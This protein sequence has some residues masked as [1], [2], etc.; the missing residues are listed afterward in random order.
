MRSVYVKIVLWLAA[1]LVTFIAGTVVTT[2]FVYRANTAG[3]SF[4]AREM[5]LQADEAVAHFKTGGP[6]ALQ[7]FLQRWT[8]TMPG[9]YLL[10]DRQGIDVLNGSDRNNLIRQRLPRPRFFS[11]FLPPRGNEIW[12]WPSSDKNYSLIVHG[13]SG[14]HSAWNALPYYLWIVVAI[15]VFSYFLALYLVSPLRKLKQS[16]EQFGRG[17]FSAR[18]D[19]RRKDEFGKL[20]QAF[21]EMADRI[22]TL[23]TAERRLLQDVSHELRSPLARLEFAVELAR[24]SP[25]RESAMDRIKKEVNRLSSLVAEL[26]QVTRAEGDPASRNLE[27]I[28]LD[29][30]VRDL[31][32]DS[33]VESEARGCHLELDCSTPIRILGDRELLRRAVENV[34]RNAIRFAPDQSAVCVNLSRHDDKAVISVRDF[35]PGVPPETLPMLFR[36]FYR[37]DSDRNRASGGV[38][39]GLAIAKRAVSLHQGVLRARNAGPGLEVE[40]EIPV[41]TNGQ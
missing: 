16:A 30:L 3:R 9:E 1:S 24:T 41:S 23:M 32:D 31:I 15:T 38:G 18:V 11:P 12:V 40:I 10:V 2:S 14:H 33:T 34:L 19:L 28:S 7:E 13:E 37:V 35:G 17:D 25:N 27:E 39:L 5:Q 6:V 26:L 22:E 20:A 29:H 8:T 21:N 4:F 36:P